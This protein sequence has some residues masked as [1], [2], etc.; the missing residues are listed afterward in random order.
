MKFGIMLMMTIVI[1]EFSFL[2]SILGVYLK[3]LIY[4]ELINTA[5][6]RLK[7]GITFGALNSLVGIISGFHILP[8]VIRLKI[9]SKKNKING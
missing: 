1:I 2:I 7:L 3:N 5:K 8:K 9:K 4:P 6:G